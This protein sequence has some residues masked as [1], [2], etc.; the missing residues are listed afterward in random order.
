MA[1]PRFSWQEY[2]EILKKLHRSISRHLKKNKLRIDAV[3]PIMRGGGVPGV[4]LAYKLHVLSILPVHYHY[5]FREKGKMKLRR[6]ISI[7]RYADL[8]PKRPVILLVEGNHCF[9]NT[10]N[11]ALKDIRANFPKATVLYAADL[12]DYGY[13]QSVKADRVFIGIY[14]NECG[15]L[16]RRQAIKKGIFPTTKLLPWEVDKEERETI[17]TKQFRYEDLKDYFDKAKV[18]KVIDLED[19]S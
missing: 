12:V 17:K 1:F 8:I 13:R 4:Y 6:F 5:D 2:E 9:G 19:S 14:T 3:V 15:T 11:A 16:T 10:A 7:K 18:V